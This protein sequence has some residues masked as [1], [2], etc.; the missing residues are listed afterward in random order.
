MF[1][2]DDGRET[3]VQ[4]YWSYKNLPELSALPVDERRVAWRRAVWRA[5]ERWQTWAAYLLFVP[6]VLGS[7][8]IG[9]LVGHEEIGG[10]VGLLIAVTISQQVVFRIARSYLTSNDSSSGG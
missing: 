6:L 9:L 8:W 10:I 5:W 3:T 1:I 7:W 4:F 2:G